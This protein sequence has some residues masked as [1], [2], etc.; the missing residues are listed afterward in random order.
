MSSPQLNKTDNHDYNKP[1][2]G[3]KN[4]ADEI[5]NNWDD[6]D[7][8]VLLRGTLSNRPSAGTKGRAY[9]ATDK[10]K[11]YHD[12]GTEW[13]LQTSET[14]KNIVESGDKVTIENN[15]TMTIAGEYK[16]NGELEINGRLGVL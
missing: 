13:I 4:W 7:V 1:E 6:L 3:Y 5:N 14:V 12:N 10:R 8:D 9:L 16:V 2:A 15:R 11:L